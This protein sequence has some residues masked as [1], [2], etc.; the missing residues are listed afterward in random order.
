MTWLDYVYAFA[1]VVLGNGWYWERRARNRSNY[2]LR[3][4]IKSLEN[5]LGL[6]RTAAAEGFK[7]ARQ[8]GRFFGN[9][10]GG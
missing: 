4:Q 7:E 8:G 5:T 3:Q 6:Q 1:V 9:R 10:K 2:A